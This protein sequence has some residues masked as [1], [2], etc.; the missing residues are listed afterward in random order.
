MSWRAYT[1]ALALLAGGCSIPNQSHCGNQAG[2]SSCA[3]RDPARP[4]CNLCEASNNGCVAEPVAAEAC[5]RESDSGAPPSTT[6]TT[7]TTTTGTT[8]GTTTDATTSTT[9]GTTTEAG[10]SS[11]TSG[12]SPEECVTQKNGKYECWLCCQ[13]AV[14]SSEVY[15]QGLLACV[16]HEGDPCRDACGDDLCVDQIVNAPCLDC[17]A[18]QVFMDTCFVAAAYQCSMA[19][20]CEQFV[21]CALPCVALP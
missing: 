7:G 10:T 19:P 18:P 3:E 17:I 15:V 1:A 13:D 12:V 4:Y 20:A 16:C 11:S 21:D 9:T 14:P 2:D 5:H 8:T 6:T